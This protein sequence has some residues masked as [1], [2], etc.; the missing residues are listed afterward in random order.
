MPNALDLDQP[1][2]F[3]EVLR[4]LGRPSYAV[5][6]LASGNV[7][8]VLRQGA[9][10]VGDTVDAFL[11]G[12]LI[13]ELSGKDDSPEFSDLLA[14]WG[15]PKMDPGLLKTGV[16][17]LGGIATDPLTY[18]GGLGIFTKPL[19]IGGQL[20]RKGVT[21]LPKG[22]A[23]L[24][25]FDETVGA[26]GAFVRRMAGA[27]RLSPLGKSAIDA[28]DAANASG[29]EVAAAGAREALSGLAAEDLDVFG[30]V[31]RNVGPDGEQVLVPSVPNTPRAIQTKRVMEKLQPFE[32]PGVALTAGDAYKRVAKGSPGTPT[33]G[34]SEMLGADP[35]KAPTPAKFSNGVDIVNDPLLPNVSVSRIKGST[36][37][38]PAV[39]G[40]VNEPLQDFGSLFAKNADT[41][42]T[43]GAKPDDI[44]AMLGATG[45]P[46]AAREGA[47]LVTNPGEAAMFTSGMSSKVPEMARVAPDDLEKALFTNRGERDDIINSI[48]QRVDASGLPP[49]Q[50]ARL[51]DAIPKYVDLKHQ[52]WQER[53]NRGVVSVPPGTDPAKAFADYMPRM[54][55]EED[56]LGK[57]FS[58]ANSGGGL[59]TVLPRGY[60]TEEE[61]MKAL[62]ASGKTPQF[63]IAKV[64]GKYAQQQAGL[65][66][67]AEF[68]K[69]L[70]SPYITSAEEKLSA[71]KVSIEKW[72]QMAD[73]ER[74]ALTGLTPAEA[75]ALDAKGGTLFGMEGAGA[76][77]TAVPKI[78]EEIGRTDRETA[79]ALARAWT[80]L[81]GRGGFEKALAA[82]N[83]RFKPFATA[84]AFIPRIN[85]NVRNVM[86]GM[87]QVLSNPEARHLW[88][89]YAKDS[90]DMLWGS[91]NDGINHIL[92][93]RF[94]SEDKFKV[95]TD[96]ING[97]R[98]SLD[99]AIN[100]LPEGPMREALRHGVVSNTFADSELLAKEIAQHGWKKSYA[101]IRDWPAKIAQGSEKRM[102][103]SIF[104]G[105]V[106]GGMPS[107]KA[108]RIVK[109]TFFDYKQ[110]SVANRRARD[111][112]PFFQ[113][114][115]KAIPQTVKVMNEK[116]WLIAATRP[117]FTQDDAE[118]R[119][120]P[121]WLQKQVTIPLGEGADGNPE[122]LTSLGLPL[123]ALA[124]VPNFSAD[125]MDFGK[126]FRQNV[127]GA[128]N[129]LL[130]T[131]YSTW[132]GQD[133]YFGSKW[134]SYDKAPGIARALG[135]DERSQLAAA[136]NMLAGA[137]VIQPL[138]SPINTLSGLF[139]PDESLT[140]GLVNTLTG[141]KIKS[142]DEQAALRQLLNDALA[143]NP[144]VQSFSTFSSTTEDPQTLE[145][146]EQLKAVK[147]AMKERKQALASSQ[148]AA[149]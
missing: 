49:E 86:G 142:V 139:S 88:P 110:N 24:S 121:A 4:Y 74:K 25:A 145:M 16:D 51:K 65:L 119:P 132:T 85:F 108:A 48:M 90:A 130:K 143:N 53:I 68:A 34:I 13:P 102:R 96:A 41:V 114:T 5:R 148:P 61:Y 64:E 33:D 116:P 131:A 39:R 9:D 15:L 109:D 128:A 57:L 136:Y 75:A 40:A 124:S 42:S 17:V 29:G 113:F 58:P 50:A 99:N 7:G 77:K 18:A 6:N 103:Y 141:A 79:E 52:Q 106:K 129:P 67:R 135:A 95:M 82:I 144:K 127:I 120:L 47:D 83:N 72:T 115:A 30:R 149:P 21:S 111:V 45:I 38:G 87:M 69:V 92:G 138:A 105:L 62:R 89:K 2:A 11:P 147:R 117:L 55:K 70:T 107:E 91:V 81:E 122:Y 8:G 97:A 118:D 14:N 104:E 36:P 23:A 84:G 26:T 59:S 76:L 35:F 134:G 46:R 63:D 73:A 44:A 3:E 43:P 66:G 94:A 19:S 10:L 98:G 12:D 101:D 78:I 20:A 54:L 28:M 125:V 146:L 22:A 133:P 140:A 1:S 37:L 60:V 71:A 31:M 80:G 126:Q 137:G 93:R 123:E 100:A 112:I 56:D 32:S 27:E